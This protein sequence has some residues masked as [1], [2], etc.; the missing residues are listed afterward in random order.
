VVG[1]AAHRA[2][3]VALTGSARLMSAERVLAAAR[4]L[5]ASG[6]EV[7]TAQVQATR[8]RT[9]GGLEQSLA[10]NPVLLVTGVRP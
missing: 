2:V 7:D 8:F 3:V 10:V 6:L 1:A 4:A 9:D 5:A